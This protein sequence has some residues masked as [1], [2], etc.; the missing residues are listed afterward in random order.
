MPSDAS[1]CLIL[2]ATSLHGGSSQ[3]EEGRAAE[4][5]GVYL[6]S[7]WL[8]LKSGNK[9]TKFRQHQGK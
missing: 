6:K 7:G 2:L 4:Q 3:T 5:F 1:E 9:N 8:T